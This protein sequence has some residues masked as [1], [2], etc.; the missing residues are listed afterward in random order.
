MLKKTNTELLYN[1]IV[2]GN[3]LRINSSSTDRE[4]R[5]GQTVTLYCTSVC[6]S[7]QLEVTWFRDGHAL[8]E[9][10]PALQLGPLTAKDSGNYTCAMKTKTNTRSQPYS[11]SVEEGLLDQFNIFRVVVLC[12]FAFNNTLYT[13]KTTLIRK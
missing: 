13:I 5:T 7:H 4:L 10:G 6:T 2:D 9:S 3:K 1:F 11:L 8:S 12:L